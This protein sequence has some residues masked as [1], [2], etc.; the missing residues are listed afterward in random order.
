MVD[1]LPQGVTVV[2]TEAEGVE[3]TAFARAKERGLDVDV[4]KAQLDGVSDKGELARRYLARND[5]L[6]SDCDL[7]VAFIDR[8]QGAAWNCVTAAHSKG[9]TVKV[10]RPTLVM[11][12][13]PEVDD[14]ED[15][16]VEVALPK[17]SRK[18][19]K[20]AG[21]FA[22]K[23]VG[24]GS[25][26]LRR[27]CYLTDERWAEIVAQKRQAP[28][29]LADAMIPEFVRFFETGQRF[30]CIHAITTPPRSIKHLQAPHVMDFV[31]SAVAPAIG[32][33]YVPF[34]E[35]W[36]KTTYGRNAKRGEVRVRPY[37][38]QFVGKVVWVLDD[39]TSSN[40]TLRAS[41][42]ALTGLG[43]H[44]HGLAYVVL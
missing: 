39:I 20:G 26:A 35:A 27:R 42:S 12:P 34:F 29:R 18:R 43:I 33:E 36:T 41:V 25:Y 17:R 44:A 24:L 19:V 6:V 28:E 21:P 1:E 4:V 30:G 8:A 16:V 23:R 14:D 2:T 22:I 3:S 38:G 5:E 13:A 15:S 7:L 9:K 31:C 32:T 11:T 37:V 40:A 10:I